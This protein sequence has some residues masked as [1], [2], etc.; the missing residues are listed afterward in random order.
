M[1][2]SAAKIRIGGMDITVQISDDLIK[3]D[4]RFGN[5]S[6]VN[7]ILTVAGDIQEQHMLDTFWHEFIEALDHLYHLNLKQRQIDCIATGL[8]QLH[9]DNNVDE[10]LT[11]LRGKA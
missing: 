5:F 4:E 8:N 9:E 2:E 10:I 1:R 3:D 6:K 7:Q 11:G